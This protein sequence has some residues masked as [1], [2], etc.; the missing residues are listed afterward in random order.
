MGH[1]AKRIIIMM[2]PSH[3]LTKRTAKAEPNYSNNNINASGPD[4]PQENEY[5]DHNMGSTTP[6]EK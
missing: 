6:I 2:T 1:L 3:H 4:R 5:Q